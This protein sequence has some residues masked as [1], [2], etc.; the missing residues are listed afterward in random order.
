MFQIRTVPSSFLFSLS[1]VFVC[2]C[3]YCSLFPSPPP[4]PLHYRYCFIFKLKKKHLL[5]EQTCRIMGHAEEAV[6]VCTCIASVL[7]IWVTSQ[8]HYYDK[9][10]AHES[11]ISMAWTTGA[12]ITGEFAKKER[13]ACQVRCLPGGVLCGGV[14]RGSILWCGG[15]GSHCS[16]FACWNVCRS[17]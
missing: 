12:G 7:W 15:G 16:N 14:A 10:A 13:L 2:C 5:I 1:F 6:R 9:N 4:S 3:C 17:R 8:S 11:N